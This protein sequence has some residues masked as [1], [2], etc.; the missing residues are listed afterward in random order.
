M[1]KKSKYN[2]NVKH[3]FFCQNAN[4]RMILNKDLKN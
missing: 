2:Q 4:I 1:N 3:I